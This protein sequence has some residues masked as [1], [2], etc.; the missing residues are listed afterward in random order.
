MATAKLKRTRDDAKR[1]RIIK[2]LEQ[3]GCIKGA[4]EAGGLD[5]A[6]MKRM[7]ARLGIPR[8]YRKKGPHGTSLPQ[9]SAD[10]DGSGDAA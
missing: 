1:R 3:H 4:A 7:M 8:D 9:A 6:N 5:R 2:L 10:S